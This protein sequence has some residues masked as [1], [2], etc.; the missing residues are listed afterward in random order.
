MGYTTDFKGS[1]TLDKPLTAHQKE[2]LNMF[3]NT[4]RMTRDPV[5]IQAMRDA[6]K[7]NTRCFQLMDALKLPIGH[8]GEFYCG[9]GMSGQDGGHFNSSTDNSV[10]EYNQAPGERSGGQPGLWCQWNPSEDGTEIAWDGSE[11]F[12]HYTEWLEYLI[13]VFLKPWGYKVNGMV[14]WVGEDS[15]DIGVIEVVDNVVETHEGKTIAHLE[16]VRR[17]TESA[18]AASESFKGRAVPSVPLMVEDIIVDL[19]KLRNELSNSKKGTSVACKKLDALI[20]KYE[21]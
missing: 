2:Y 1:F 12:Y 11:K 20:A 6:G 10:V 4:R 13:D 8:N 21:A 14:E 5:K 18:I 19:V 17:M 7:G 15:S 9:T 16:D 3:A